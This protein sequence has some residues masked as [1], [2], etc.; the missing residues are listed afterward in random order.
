M[1]PNTLPD[2]VCLDFMARA[3]AHAT[4]S[5]MH[6]VCAISAVIETN[7]VLATSHHVMEALH[8]E[9]FRSSVRVKT[10]EKKKQK[11]ESKINEPAL[12]QDLLSVRLAV[13]SNPK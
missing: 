1:L 10:R 11:L 7:P 8:A 3:V 2:D 12:D 9:Q 5:T 4:G 13:S 6:T